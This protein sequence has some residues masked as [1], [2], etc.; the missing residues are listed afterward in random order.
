MMDRRLMNVSEAGD[1]NALYELFR[2]DPFILESVD[3]V[4]FLDT[5]LHIAVSAGKSSFAMEIANLKPSFAKKLNQDGLSPIHLA[6]AMG[7]VGMVKELLT[8]GGRELCLLKGKEKRTPLHIAVMYGRIDVI[9]VLMDEFPKAL[10]D[11]TVSKETAL[12]LALKYQQFDTFKLLLDW[13]K[14]LNTRDVVNLKDNEGNTALHLAITS[15]APRQ[16]D[17]YMIKDLICNFVS[18]VTVNAMNANNQTALDVLLQLPGEY[19]EIQDILGRAKA[20]RSDE[21]ISCSQ[22]HTSDQSRVVAKIPRHLRG[23]IARFR[24]EVVSDYSMEVRSALLVVAVLTATATFQ[25]G[26]TPPGGVWQDN[27][28]PDYNNST[29]TTTATATP[30]E[31]AHQAG[32]AIMATDLSKFTMFTFFNVSGFLISYTMIIILTTGFPFSSFVLLALSFMG[33]TYVLSLMT[34]TPDDQGYVIPYILQALLTVPM[35]SLLY[36]IV[37]YFYR[38]RSEYWKDGLN[39][40]GA[41]RLLK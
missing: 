38:K 4:P 29:N 16:A 6:S 22:P 10:E 40:K 17:P 41:L 36:Q 18:G 13:V 14:E 28:Y 39:W 5:P 24:R 20:K 9:N 33:L 23:W 11:L 15:R 26:V 31:M 35:L 34:I 1:I 2:E 3:Q 25:T 19:R 8:T 7:D 32:R 27:F 21:I 12:H 30:S 37:I